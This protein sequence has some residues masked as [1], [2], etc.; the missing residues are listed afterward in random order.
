MLASSSTTAPPAP[1]LPSLLLLLLHCCSTT[2]AST[3]EWLSAHLLLCAS[4]VF[5]SCSLHLERPL[6][7]RASLFEYMYILVHLCFRCARVEL[8][9]AGHFSYEGQWISGVRRGH[10]SV[11]M[12]DGERL[13]PDQFVAA[14]TV[15]W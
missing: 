3:T 14:A 12:A 7:D 2:T 8:E 4:L 1:R 10:G 15:R 6:S 13:V 9:V 11:L 5:F